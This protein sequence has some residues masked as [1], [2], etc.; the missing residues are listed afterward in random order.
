MAYRLKR[1]VMAY[2][3]RLAAGNSGL[4][5]HGENHDNHVHYGCR[6]FGGLPVNVL[7]L[8][9][10]IISWLVGDPHCHECSKQSAASCEH[11]WLT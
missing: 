8:I 11:L 10:R 1:I 7:W 9:E 4:Q 3:L 2:R 6:P 5:P